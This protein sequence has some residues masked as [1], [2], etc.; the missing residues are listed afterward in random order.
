MGYVLCGLGCQTH[1]SYAA[2]IFYL[3]TYIITSA[4]FFVLL[5]KLKSVR[6]KPI[7]YVKDLYG[8]Q[9]S[10]SI[11]AALIIIIFSFT[12]IPPFVGF[13]AKVSIIAALYTSGHIVL[14]GIIIITALISAYYYLRIISLAEFKKTG[15]RLMGGFF[16]NRPNLKRILN[17]NNYSALK[18]LMVAVFKNP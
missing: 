10:P 5:V 9:D 8:V 17:D 12:G 13:Y 16:E 1:P 7:I 6:G 4:A 11:Q 14:C 2:A 18:K 15:T 3:I